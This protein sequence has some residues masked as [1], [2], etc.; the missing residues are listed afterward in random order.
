MDLRQLQMFEAVLATLNLTK[1]AGQLFVTPSAVSL[2]LKKLSEELGTDLFVKNG[3]Q[4]VATPAAI[5]LS[6]YTRHLFEVMED[7]HREFRADAAIDSRPFVLATGL[8]T[9]MY[10][11]AGP[12]RA[13][14]RKYPH[15]EIR[16][17]TGATEY[18]MTGLRNRQF[19]LGIV[20][21]P[22]SLDG[23]RATPLY[24]EE[25]V[26][27]VNPNHSA[28]RGPSVTAQDL[29]RLRFILYPHGSNIRSMIDRFFQQ[30]GI[31]PNVSMELDNVEAIRRL[32]EY[33]YAASFLPANALRRNSKALRRLHMDGLR[34]DRQVAL[35]VPDTRY[36]RRL[37]E[38]IS[39]FLLEA[40][41]PRRRS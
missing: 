17:V 2:Q 11:M 18:V 4:L 19:D 37:T 31:V 25:M 39:A 12:L 40:L 6:G 21:L 36:S 28:V 27:V 16:I 35:A 20:S 5:R 26:L 30:A 29:S 14:K 22:V 24:S 33:G 23:I 10:R 32:V 7:L 1:A 38:S 15:N 34:V 41:A 3:H 8:T 13:L 9:L